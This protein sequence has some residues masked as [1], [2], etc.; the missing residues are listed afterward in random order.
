MHPKDG[1][2]NTSQLTPPTPEEVAKLARLS[3]QIQPEASVKKKHVVPPRSLRRRLS[4]QA[5]DGIVGRYTAGE[6]TPALSREFGISE[7]GLRN[8]LRAEGVTLRGHAIT[9]EDA[10][11]AV[12][13]Y[14]GGW[15]ITQVV[16][17][18]G[19][20]HGTIRSALLKRGTA[21]RS[22]GQGKRMVS[23]E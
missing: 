20:S 14:E 2:S 22:G 15:T 8:L 6:K 5:I 18:I 3:R 12:Q 23:S 19:Y 13:L 10:E 1:H 17:H 11:R 21:I 4:P 9:P 7:S 16:A